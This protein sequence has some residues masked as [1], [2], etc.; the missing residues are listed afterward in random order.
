MFL[1]IFNY[2]YCTNLYTICTIY[3]EQRKQVRFPTNFLIFD[4]NKCN[5]KGIIILLNILHCSTWCELFVGMSWASQLHFM[6]TNDEIKD[7]HHDKATHLIF[8]SVLYQFN[9][10]C[11]ILPRAPWNIHTHSLDIKE[12]FCTILLTAILL[13]LCRVSSMWSPRLQWHCHWPANTKSI[14]S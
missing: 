10:L 14:I 1:Y 13:P 7:G 8:L 12:L 5:Y 2:I 4:W 3:L 6:V 9:F 11:Q